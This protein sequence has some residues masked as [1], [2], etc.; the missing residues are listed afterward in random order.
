LDK[1]TNEHINIK[2]PVRNQFYEGNHEILM[3]SI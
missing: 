1:K 2:L 3:N